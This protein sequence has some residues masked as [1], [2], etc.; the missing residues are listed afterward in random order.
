MRLPVPTRASASRSS[1]LGLFSPYGSSSRIVPPFSGSSP[2]SSPNYSSGATAGETRTQKLERI[3]DELLD[4][5]KLE[6]H[7]YTVLFGL[8]LGLNRWGPAVAVSPSASGAGTEG[9]KGAGAAVAAA[10][11][12]TFDV[13]LEKFDAAGKIRVIK[14][15]R[16]FTDLGLKEAKDLVEKAPVVVKKQVTKE[17]AEQI[18]AKLKGVGATVVLE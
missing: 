10:E 3:A 7:D 15:V 8:K 4:L 5:N 13:K 18:A 9:A 17:E 2:F 11:K 6:R 14:E 16:G 12:S 1:L